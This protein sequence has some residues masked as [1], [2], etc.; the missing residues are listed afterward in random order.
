MR[1][2]VRDV[3]GTAYRTGDSCKSIISRSNRFQFIFTD[4]RL[5]LNLDQK[6]QPLPDPPNHKLELDAHFPVNGIEIESKYL[7]VN[8]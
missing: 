2:D 8:H 4:L 6:L 7:R 5:Q 1:D 3:H